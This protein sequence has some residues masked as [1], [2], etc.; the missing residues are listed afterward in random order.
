MSAEAVSESLPG[1][2]PNPNPAT[3]V[4]SGAAGAPL[5]AAQV[6]NRN[7][8][9][10]RFF[11][12]LGI[13]FIH[14]SKSPALDDWRNIARFAVP[15][16]LFASFYYQSQSL[17]RK[18][19]RTLGQYIVSRFRRLYLPFLAWS[20]IYFLARNA[21]HFI[22]HGDN[23]A[24]RPTLGMLWKGDQYHLWFLPYLLF[25][26]IVLAL[27]HW[28]FLRQNRAWRWP[29]IAVA[30]VA[31]FVFALAPMPAWDEMFPS[32]TYA[33]IQFWRSLPATFWGLA[34]AWF[35]TMG[36]VLYSVPPLLGALG[37]VLAVVTSLMQVTKG[38]ILLIPRGLS[39][40]GCMLAALVPWRSAATDVLA[41]LGKHS[42]GIYLSHVLVVESLR[43]V[44]NRL[45]LAASV[46]LD[47][48]I[49][50]VGFVLSLALVLLLARSRKTAWLNG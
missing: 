9:V 20:L 3:A 41:D 49:F 46:P 23:E 40:L 48:V 45:H 8:D 6:R 31:G 35:M 11:A 12:A 17:R 4:D 50:A 24:V 14:A 26:S 19:N 15:F 7:I 21:K 47:F 25:W 34:F 37:I 33:Y 32:E 27:I 22:L 44:T 28:T 36:P 43:L 38:A 2:A 29:L 10:V 1:I 39:G 30:I 5:S 16:Y 13:V 42:Y 18:T